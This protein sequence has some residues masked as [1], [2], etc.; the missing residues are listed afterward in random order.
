MALAMYNVFGKEANQLLGKARGSY[1][2]Y[3]IQN[4]TGLPISVWSDV[5]GSSSA[6]NA[7]VT[8]IAN[9][10]TIDWRFDDWKTMREVSFNK[11]LCSSLLTLK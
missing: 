10:Q 9:E 4:H 1:A 7:V 11:Y 6:T 8:E 5:E 2:P 3:R